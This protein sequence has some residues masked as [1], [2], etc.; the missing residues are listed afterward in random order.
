[1]QENHERRRAEQGT[2]IGCGKA[3][4][5]CLRPPTSSAADS[6]TV[7]QGCKVGGNPTGGDRTVRVMQ[8]YGPTPAPCSEQV[9][10]QLP[11]LDHRLGR[12]PLVE[13]AKLALE[14]PKCTG[15]GGTQFRNFGSKGTK[16]RK[17]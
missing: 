5:N 16:R 6:A 8:G 7:N 12:H 11:Q 3:P 2:P 10:L 15:S 9:A 14:G 13:R 1:M 4:R 17:P